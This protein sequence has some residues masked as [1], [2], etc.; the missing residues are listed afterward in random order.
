MNPEAGEISPHS[1][2][3]PGMELLKS[4]AY[5]QV[6]EPQIGAPSSRGQSDL[7]RP[8]STPRYQ[9]WRC[10]SDYPEAAP[11]GLRR[12]G[13]KPEVV[14]RDSRRPTKP[15]VAIQFAPAPNA[16]STGPSFLCP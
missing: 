14:R 3:C 1:V 6:T 16:R 7:G 9:A 2:S 5:Q 12:P 8:R 13:K 11:G 15:V 4:L 10:L